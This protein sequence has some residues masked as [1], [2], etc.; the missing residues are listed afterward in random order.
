MVDPVDNCHYCVE[1]LFWKGDTGYSL[2]DKIEKHR[3]EIN[4]KRNNVKTLRIL[5]AINFFY[6][7]DGL[8]KRYCF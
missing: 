1:G 5:F 4:N 2:G 3:M 8:P 6:N 7:N